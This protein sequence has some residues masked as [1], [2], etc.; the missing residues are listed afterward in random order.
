[1]ALLGYSKSPETDRG[2]GNNSDEMDRSDSKSATVRVS[3]EHFV[4][5]MEKVV[6]R[7][8]EM[9]PHSMQQ[10]KRDTFDPRDFRVP[11]SEIFSSSFNKYL[12][13]ACFS[14]RICILTTAISSTE[15]S[16]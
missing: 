3:V 2:F 16:T 8:D 1:M 12:I 14:C 10:E 9:I 6:A 11:V 4:S 5:S 13:T 15:D 7:A